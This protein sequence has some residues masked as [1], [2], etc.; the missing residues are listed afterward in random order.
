MCVN[1]NLTRANGDETLPAAACLN[2][3]ER[4]QFRIVIAVKPVGD[5]AALALHVRLLGQLLRKAIVASHENNIVL[6]FDDKDYDVSSD[7]F[8]QCLHSA[9]GDR[10]ESIVA[11]EPF[12]DVRTL[13]EVVS[14]C[15]SI[16]D[17]P[18]SGGIMRIG[19]AYEQLVSHLVRDEVFKAVPLD[20]RVLALVRRGY[21]E[22]LE[23]GR[24]LM[25]DLYAY[26]LSGGNAH[27]ASR[28][29]FLHRNTLLY[30][31]KQLEEL[32]GYDLDA[33]EPWQVIYL[34]LSCLAALH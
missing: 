15:L 30:R 31:M 34:E 16:V 25:G 26:L 21:R 19:E 14:Q 7:V 24:E 27:A 11:S 33:L 22:D 32:L 2:G 6:L 18:S 4:T 10:P 9:L 13:L 29:L 1:L 8:L 23:K 3:N 12:V 17:L 28:M 5:Q 20:T